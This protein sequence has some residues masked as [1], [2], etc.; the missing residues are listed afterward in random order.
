MDRYSDG[1]LDDI[2]AETVSHDRVLYLAFPVT[3]PAG[4]SVS[5][6]CA[7]WKEPSFDYACSGS[8]NE[9]LQGYDLTTRLGSALEFTR[10]SAVLVNTENVDLTGQNFGFDP[11]RGVTAVELDLNEAHYYM[12]LRPKS[13]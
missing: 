5:L 8:D 7:L 13:E 1:R 12:E 4:G 11:E 9:G 3:V 10:Q 6:E 2:L